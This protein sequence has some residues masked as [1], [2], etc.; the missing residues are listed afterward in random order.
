[1]IVPAWVS[2]IWDNATMICVYRMLT[3]ESVPVFGAFQ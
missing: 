3:L 1:M 2:M